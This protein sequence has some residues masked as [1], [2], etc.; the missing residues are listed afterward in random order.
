MPS[1]SS[2]GIAVIEMLNVLEGY[3]LKAN[4]Y[5]AAQNLNLVAESMRRAFADRAQRIAD[6]D[7]V[8]G[9]PVAQLISKDYAAQVRKTINPNKASVSTPTTFTWP[10]ESQE[11]THLSVADAKRTAVS[12][13]DTLEYGYG[14]RIVV[15]GAGFPLN[16]ELGDFNSA[17]EMTDDHGNIGTKANLAL[18]GKRPLSSMSPTIL[19][20]DGKLFM[21]TGSPGGG[22]AG[23]PGGH[24][25]GGASMAKTMSAAAFKAHCLEVLDTV[26]NTSEPVVVT[27]R[28]KPVARVVPMLNKPTRLLGAMRGRI[29]TVGDSVAPLGI[30]WS[31]A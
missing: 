9:I 27:K 31:E 15:P 17:P 20:K 18:P 2:G 16:N 21:V 23:H 1:P 26:A 29:A 4:G 30:P 19:A 24:D 25:P 12:M 10:T 6:P 22:Y 5:G 28:G 7:F 11:T 13:T 8:A 14:S 3:D